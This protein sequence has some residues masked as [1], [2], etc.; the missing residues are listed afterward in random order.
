MLTCK[1]KSID[2]QLFGLPRRI[3]MTVIKLQQRRESVDVQRFEL[4]GQFFRIHDRLS[5]RVNCFFRPSPSLQ[6]GFG[7]PFGHVYG[8]IS[9][10]LRVSS[11]C[12]PTSW[13]PFSFVHNRQGSCFD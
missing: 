5:S 1:S 3:V 11:G 10:P 2:N 6:L 7:P 12:T 13:M 4:V 9:K 8:V